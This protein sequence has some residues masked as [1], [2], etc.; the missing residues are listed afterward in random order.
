MFENFEMDSLKNLSRNFVELEDSMKR[1][2]S[3][4]SETGYE[5][6]KTFDNNLINNVTKL[7]KGT[8]TLKD[9]LKETARTIAT[10]FVQTQ[11]ST[12]TGKSGGGSTFGKILGGIGGLFFD[13][14]GVVPGSF[15]QPVPVIAHGS[16][17][18]LNP[19]QQANLFKMLNGQAQ[20]GG[21]QSNYVYAPQVTTGASA[22]EVFDVLNRHS[23]QFFS[24]VAEGVQTNNS[25]RNA[26]RGA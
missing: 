8:T 14:G 22:Q 1:I 11:I 21:G 9:I 5:F 15:S 2:R 4:T 19:G 12:Y 17:M 20:G 18:I 16:E 24:M 7:V 10:D 3:V 13:Q 26:V 23:R 6:K 25:L